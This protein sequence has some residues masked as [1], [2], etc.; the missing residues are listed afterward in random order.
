M[1]IDTHRTPLVYL[2]ITLPVLPLDWRRVLPYPCGAGKKP[3]LGSFTDL[4]YWLARLPD[5]AALDCFLGVVWTH[6]WEMTH[7]LAVS[8][9]LFWK[10]VHVGKMPPFV[11]SNY[12]TCVYV[13]IT[14]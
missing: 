6:I 3:L 14:T 5:G 7:L 13:T 12:N 11:C 10:S 1:Y 4:I 8:A 9:G 2:Q